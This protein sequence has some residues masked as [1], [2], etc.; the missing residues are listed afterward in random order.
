MAET[1]TATG[2]MTPVTLMEAPSAPTILTEET[3]TM[4]AT[5][6]LGAQTT[7]TAETTT[8]TAMAAQTNQAMT[9]T[10]ALRRRAIPTE[11]TMTAMEAPRSLATHT[12]VMIPTVALS[13]QTTP[14]EETITTTAMAAQTNQAMTATAALRSHPTPMETTMT[15]MEALKSLATHT[16]MTIPTAARSDPITLMAATIAPTLMA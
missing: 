14:M 3:T 11:T 12:A 6:A 8:A 5:V 7:P 1:T 2:V 13:D 9:A 15:A 10:A 16:V 4:I